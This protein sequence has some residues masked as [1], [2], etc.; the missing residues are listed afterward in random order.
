[1]PTPTGI[2]SP[3]EAETGHV[4]DYKLAQWMGQYFPKDKP[5]FDFGCGPGEYLR[6]FHDIGFQKLKGFEGTT[7]SF[8]FGNVEVR[9][10][11]E[12]F[13]DVQIGNVICLEV[14]EHIPE[15]YTDVFLDNL[16]RHLYGRLILS[17]AIPGQG[18]LGH[19]N[20]RHNIWVIEKM[21]TL[22]LSLRVLDT[23]HSRQ[24]VSNNAHW[25][26]NTLM[27]FEKA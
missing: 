6:Y 12:S 4:F 11:T 15:Q 19:V 13:Q 26:R 3:E 10:I 21:R 14:A 7:L 27:V 2:W 23:L 24:M 5:L 17:W 16:T 22:G 25:F 20:C 8:E 18:G 1:M 9:D